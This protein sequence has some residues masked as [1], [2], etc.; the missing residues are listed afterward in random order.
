MTIAAVRSRI[1]GN[2]WMKSGPTAILAYSR[3]TLCRS[4]RISS[5][6]ENRVVICQRNAFRQDITDVIVR[7]YNPSGFADT[8]EKRVTV[9]AA[10]SH[11]KTRAETRDVRT[12]MNCGRGVCRLFERGSG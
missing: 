3:K 7:Q 8:A 2:V 9:T 12:E 11:V 5:G 10:S 6:T 1:V 4:S